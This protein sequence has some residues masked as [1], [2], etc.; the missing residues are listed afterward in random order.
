MTVTRKIL[1][2]LFVSLLMAA[3]L[4]AP[5]APALAA[6]NTVCTTVVND[7]LSVV[8]KTCGAAPIMNAWGYCNV[9]PPNLKITFYRNQG[10]CGDSVQFNKTALLVCR[11]MGSWS[12]WAASVIN[13]TSG[14]IISDRA[15]CTG[16]PSQ[17]MPGY[18]SDPD[19]FYNPNLG[20]LVSGFKSVE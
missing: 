14:L 1:T 6:T 5:A 9:N 13:Y 18:T 19:L 4:S 11:E 17:G 3:G 8:S 10:Y 7:D 16:S 20:R 12:N 15:D 2:A